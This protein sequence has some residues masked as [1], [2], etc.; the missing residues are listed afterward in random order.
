MKFL[1]NNL[2]PF[3]NDNLAD[4]QFEDINLYSYL[5]DNF[6]DNVLNTRK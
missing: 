4:I 1:E 3:R 6:K 2:K 5:K